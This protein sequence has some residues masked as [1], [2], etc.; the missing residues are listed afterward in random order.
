MAE[1]RD[2]AEVQTGDGGEARPAPA[3][4]LDDSPHLRTPKQARSR[5]TL[6]R[7][8]DAALTLIA[9]R[10]VEETS[11]QD[12]VREANS[13]VGSFY[14]RFEGK[15]DLLCYLEDRLWSDAERRWH[16]ALE[17]HA[18]DELDLDDLVETV[19][20]LLLESYRAGARTRRVLESRK[21]VDGPS[22]A[23]R[24]FHL[25][26]RSGIRDLLMAHADAMNH[27][28]PRLAIDV[29][30]AV[31]VGAIRE[32]EE[33]PELASV[34]PDLGDDARCAELAR[35]Y[36]AYLGTTNPRDGNQMDFFDIWG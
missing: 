18:F 6:K 35:L 23:A 20:R 27:P 8:V 15:E 24:A 22:D 21:G 1:D 29:G 2:T 11:I 16:D 30:L 17:S 10:G 33:S 31:V 26:L 34:L 9:E 19:V 36:K 7:I 5:K 12:I 3:R 4:A 14:A 25:R 32:F 28:D 13:S